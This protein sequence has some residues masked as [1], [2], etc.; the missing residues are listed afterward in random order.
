MFHLYIGSSWFMFDFFEHEN[1]EYRE[2]LEQSYNDHFSPNLTTGDLLEIGKLIKKW[3]GEPEERNAGWI[4]Y[5]GLLQERVNKA[6]NEID[7]C[8]IELEKTRFYASGVDK[9]IP[10]RDLETIVGQYVTEGIVQKG[11]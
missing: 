9:W 11:E 3:R 8:Y 7:K 4:H 6:Q 10:V 1:Q 2:G 5:M